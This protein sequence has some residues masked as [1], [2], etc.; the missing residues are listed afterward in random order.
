MRTVLA[1]LLLGGRQWPDMMLL[2]KPAA[3]LGQGWNF[4][5]VPFDCIMAQTQKMN[6]EVSCTEAFSMILE[7]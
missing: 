2:T 4:S 3:G 5:L 7:R 1:R 6:G